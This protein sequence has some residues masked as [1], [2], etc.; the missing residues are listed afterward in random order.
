MSKI[1]TTLE[2]S[3]KLIELGIDANTADMY[4]DYDVQKHE[5]YPMVMD[6]QFDDTCV[7]AWSLAALLGVLPMIRKGEDT[8]N[9]FIAKTPDGEYYIVYATLTKEVYD[10]SMYDNPIDA[11][12]AMIENLHELNLL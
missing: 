2:Q 4:W 9:P 1:C 12:V 3:K 6:E 5:Y 8:A 10:S 7:R 11:C